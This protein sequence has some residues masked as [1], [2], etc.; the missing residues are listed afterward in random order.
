MKDQIKLFFKNAFASL[1]YKHKPIG[2]SAGKLYLYLDAL[3]KTN[4]L[5]AAVIEI[6]CNVCGTTALGKEMLRKLKSQREYYA[7]DTFSGFVQEQFD[8]D[9]QFNTRVGKEKAFSANSVNLARKVLRLHKAADTK[10]IQADIVQL[11]KEKL[12]EKI[13][14]ALLD[15]DLYQPILSA[16][17]K[18][19]PRLEK[20]GIIL[21]DDCGRSDQENSWKAGMAYTEFCEKNDIPTKIEFGMGVI[22]K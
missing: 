2:L 4:K 8:F 22:M 13:S 14:M 10:L 18:I 17:D 9:R 11:D 1:I 6:G 7:V 12:P 21:V 20:G 5:T 16:L 3:K 15:V 19:Y